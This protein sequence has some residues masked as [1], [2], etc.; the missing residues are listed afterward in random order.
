MEPTVSGCLAV[1][2]GADLLP[3]ALASMRDQTHPCDEIIVIDD[4]STDDSASIAESLGARVIRQANAGIGAARRRLIEEARGDWIA[5][6]DHDDWWEPEKIERLL[7]ATRDPEVS[8]IYSGAYLVD[9]EGNR[10][11][12]QLDA[13][14]ASPRLRHLL[15]RQDNILVPAT[16][17]R[18]Q[19]LIDAGGFSSDLRIGE[20]THAFYLLASRGRI[21]QIPER[22]ACIFKRSD[23][24][25]AFSKA[26]FEHEERL[27]EDLILAKWQELFGF[28][29]MGEQF[30]ARSMIKIKLSHVK[31]ML[32]MWRQWEG[33]HSKAMALHRQAIS[34]NPR[35][36]GN[37]YRIALCALGRRVKPIGA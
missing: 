30:E 5:F 15:P 25:S 18:R 37:W 36:K 14:P 10:S 31:S 34:L 28:L 20:D 8:L 12:A 11:L 21:T 7:P 1:H 6:N 29:P 35:S 4:G 19:T 27:Y 22:L 9:E 17:I 33:D 32:G 3:R 2:N 23:S 13:S 16:L 26:L 24:T